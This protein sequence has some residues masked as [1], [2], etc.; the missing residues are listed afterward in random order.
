MRRPYIFV[1]PE[2]Y[3]TVCVCLLLLPLKLILAWLI[4][5]TVHE[6]FHFAAIKLSGGQVSRIQIGISGVKMQTAPMNHLQELFCAAA[7]PL[8]GLLLF[9]LFLKKIPMLAV[10]GLLHCVYNLIPLY[11]LDGGRILHSL[12]GVLFKGHHFDIITNTLDSSLSL[13]LLICVLF[14]IIRFAVGPIPLLLVLC[15]IFN[16]KKAKS[17]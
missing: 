15:M 3:C 6:L 5:V 16:N 13:I 7:G 17:S 8:G 12:V 10:F 1:R 9:V 14:V 4:S 11:P 2:V